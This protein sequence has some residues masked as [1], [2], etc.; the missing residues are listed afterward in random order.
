MYLL[1]KS[2]EDRLETAKSTCD[3]MAFQRYFEDLKKCEEKLPLFIK[4]TPPFDS[5]VTGVT[6][7]L[8]ERLKM[9]EEQNVK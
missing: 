3:S 5:C 8:A 1:L 7:E 9:C 6:H 2:Y 4:L